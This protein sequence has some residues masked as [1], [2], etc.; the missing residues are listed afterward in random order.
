MPDTEDR[1]ATNGKDA[2]S[3]STGR[4]SPGDT[5]RGGYAAGKAS[6]GLKPPP[7]SVSKVK[8]ASK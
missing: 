8:T 3:A 5:F 6:G 4:R 7:A 1:M 2:T